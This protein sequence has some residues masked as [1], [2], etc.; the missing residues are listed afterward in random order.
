[1][2]APADQTPGGERI[3]GKVKWFNIRRGYGFI[4][5]ADK[6]D[7]IH[8]H[9]TGIKDPEDGKKFKTLGEG[10]DVEFKIA[11]DK[12]ERDTAVEVTGP[13]GAAVQGARR[14][15]RKTTRKK[16]EDSKDDAT[17]SK[18]VRGAGE[19]WEVTWAGGVRYRN[20]TRMSDKSR[21]SAKAGVIVKVVKRTKKWVLCDNNLWLP[22]KDKDDALLAKRSSAKKA[23]KK[24]PKREKKPRKAREPR[25]IEA[26]ITDGS[27]PLWDASSA[28]K[29]KCD[30]GGENYESRQIDGEHRCKYYCFFE[31]QKDENAAEKWKAINAE[32]DKTKI[33]ELKK[34]MACSNGWS[35]RHTWYG[36]FQTCKK[37]KHVN[38]PVK[39]KLLG[40]G[41]QRVDEAGLDREPD[42]EPNPKSHQQELCGMC[43]ELGRNCWWSK[44]RA[45]LEEKKARDAAEAE[46]KANATIDDAIAE[47]TKLANGEKACVE[48]VKSFAETGKFK[49]DWAEGGYDAVIKKA[50]AAFATLRAKQQVTQVVG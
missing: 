27:I 23:P 35:S 48:L 39:I 12:S 46:K 33:A 38:Y 10:E 13:A 30:C 19:T 42:N 26:W 9:F 2:S 20:S 37:C 22:I 14:R 43:K 24:T 17:S 18:R 36:A 25:V 16:P 6:K 49:D 4:E 40:T 29:E 1:M 32:T 21:K 7:D 47:V 28:R 50:D 41:D 8:V 45:A 44:K 31:C 3:R 11:K 34:D 15:R 5:R